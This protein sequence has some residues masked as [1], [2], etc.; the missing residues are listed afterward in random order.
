[1]KENLTSYV[2]K[3]QNGLIPRRDFLKKIN[4]VILK[5]PDYLGNKSPDIKH[6]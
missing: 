6:E 2:K 4:P 1:M 5:I 3:F